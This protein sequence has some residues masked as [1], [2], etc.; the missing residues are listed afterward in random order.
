MAFTNSGTDRSSVDERF[1]YVEK[2]SFRCAFGNEKPLLI[3]FLTAAFAAYLGIGLGIMWPH[4][5]T[6]AFLFYAILGALLFIVDI[7]LFKVA[8]NII[9]KGKEASYYADSV[10]FTV[11]CAGKKEIFYY[12]DVHF[13]RFETFSSFGIPRGYIVTVCT[14]QGDFRYSCLSRKRKVFGEPQ[15]TPFFILKQNAE[16]DTTPERAVEYSQE[17]LERPVVPMV[18]SKVPE[19]SVHRNIP[20]HRKPESNIKILKEDEFVTAKG[21]FRVPYEKEVMGYIL[22]PVFF[23]AGIIVGMLFINMQNDIFEYAASLIWSL[24]IGAVWLLVIGTIFNII[25][26]GRE[27]SYISDGREFRVT[28]KG[29]TRTIYLCDVER[30]EYLPLKLLWKQRGYL[31]KI[32]T[33]YTVIEY[34]YLFPRRVKYFPPEKTPFRTIEEIIG[35]AEKYQPSYRRTE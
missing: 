25:A 12:E 35:T 27:C 23:L 28:D 33:K 32:I 31:V 10:K 6:E 11:T 24:A 18:Y 21:A 30:V 9:M 16:K 14:R 26:S 8:Y 4:Y 19:N 7:I 22:L 2:G 5:G 1:G 29:E 34:K 3:C 17:D 15:D 13:V 20:D